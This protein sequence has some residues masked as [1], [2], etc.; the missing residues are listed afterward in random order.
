M[1]PLRAA[2][3][4]CSGTDSRGFPCSNG[5]EQDAQSAFLSRQ[6]PEPAKELLTRKTVDDFGDLPHAAIRCQPLED[7][8]IS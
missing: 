1:F 7:V 8:Q 3:L 6:F 5:A 2:G 4:I